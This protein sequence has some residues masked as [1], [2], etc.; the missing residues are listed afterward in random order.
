MKLS[1]QDIKKH[2]EASEI[3]KKDSLSYDDQIFVFEN[4]R[5]DAHHVNSQRG[6]FFTPM[7]LARSFAVTT[8]G[9]GSGRVIDLC[10]GIGAL[11]WQLSGGYS[12]YEIVCVEQNPDYCEVGQKLVPN[13]K[14]ICGN[15][16][17]VLDMGLG[18]FDFAVSNPPFGSI[19]RHGGNAPR[20]SGS[21][22]EYHVMD[23]AAHISG[24]GAFILPQSSSGFKFSGERCFAREYSNKYERFHKQTGIN[25]NCSSV[26]CDFAKPLWRG[27]SPTVEIG[28]C[29]F[30]D[31]EFSH[32][33]P[34]AQ[35]L[36]GFAA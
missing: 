18:R 7:S 11:S 6:A 30:Q 16:F 10:A 32:T 4:W 29:D 28:Y 26:D 8:I 36:F 27:T 1:K 5:E 25:L 22:F 12:D 20:Y 33:V 17:D 15:V 35:S 31:T 34:V 13:A 21:G 3:L 9:A 23:I 24:L 2:D 19:N 14:W